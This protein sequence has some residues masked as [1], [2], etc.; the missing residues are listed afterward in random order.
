MQS[1]GQPG[2]AQD[3]TGRQNVL[4]GISQ[5]KDGVPAG[6]GRVELFFD[7]RGR[8]GRFHCRSAFT[9]KGAVFLAPIIGDFAILRRQPGEG[10]F[11]GPRR[12]RVGAGVAA[13]TDALDV[14]NGNMGIS[15]K[16]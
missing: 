12:Q 8:D 5:Q 2:Q 1:R 4:P 9:V 3:F 7:Q 6:L 16:S 14:K 10:L 11:D 15:I 13:G